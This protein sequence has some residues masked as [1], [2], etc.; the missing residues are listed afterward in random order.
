MPWFVAAQLTMGRFMGV[1]SD[2]ISGSYTRGVIYTPHRDGGA[3]D[4]LSPNPAGGISVTDWTE[5][6]VQSPPR[7][8]SCA[9]SQPIGL[10]WVSSSPNGTAGQGAWGGTPS[11]LAYFRF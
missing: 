4:Q 7:G 10:R 11:R 2:Q 8:P 3:D 6:K 1:P 5:G 9:Q